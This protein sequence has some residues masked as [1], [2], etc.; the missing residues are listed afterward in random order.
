MDE[1]LDAWR[2][3]LL[4]ALASQLTADFEDFPNLYRALVIDRNVRWLDELQQLLSDERSSLVVVGA[5]HLVGEDSVI[6]LLRG[7]GL[8]V[9]AVD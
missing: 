4:D 6:E 1:L 3:G 8:T 9:V 5:L 7:R 2:D